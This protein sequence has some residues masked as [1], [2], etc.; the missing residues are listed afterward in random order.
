M[1]GYIYI[2]TN[3]INDKKYIGSSVNYLK[4]KNSHICYL[5]SN[6]HHSQHLQNA[7]NK[8]GEENFKFKSIKKILND[9]KE[10]LSLE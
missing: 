1:I 9:A 10:L 7:Y 4:R 3:I 2:I 8:Y 6:K 5:R